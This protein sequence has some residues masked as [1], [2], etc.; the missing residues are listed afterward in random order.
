MSEPETITLDSGSLEDLYALSREIAEQEQ[1]PWEPRCVSAMF[2]TVRQ[3]RFRFTMQAWIDLDAIRSP[4]LDGAIP[5]KL[6]EIDE[7]LSIFGFEVREELEADEYI[8]LS[9]EML[10]VVNQGFAMSLGMR[11]P[12]E[13]ESSSARPE[14]F[15]NWLPLVACMVTQFKI[16]YETV[17]KMKVGEALALVACSR[18]NQGWESEGTPYKLRESE[19]GAPEPEAAATPA[20][21]ANNG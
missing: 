12:N 10:E 18:H 14:H 17:L 20:E 4:L 15:G 7:A 19:E 8:A 2:S 5:R 16:P 13:K 1:S 6:E 11:D 3:K 21:D 9:E